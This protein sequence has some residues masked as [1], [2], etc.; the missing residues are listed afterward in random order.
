MLQHGQLEA[1]GAECRKLSR[2][3]VIAALM[4]HLVLTIGLNK[5]LLLSVGMLDWHSMLPQ[6]S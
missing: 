1:Q 3:A 6:D 5:G 4:R 2:G